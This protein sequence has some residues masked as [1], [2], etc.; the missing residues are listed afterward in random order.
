PASLVDEASRE[1]PRLL[2]GSAELDRVLGG[3]LVLGSVHL[4][5]GE[6]GIGKSCVML[7]TAAPLAGPT[8]YATGEESLKQ[9]ALRAR[10][11]GLTAA[12][13]RLVAETR[14]G[15]HGRAA[16]EP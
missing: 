14:G 7:Q 4:I 9:V 1:E 8:L 11:L 6:S 12:A 13:T 15:A 10:R 2:T 5:G 16:G 3:G